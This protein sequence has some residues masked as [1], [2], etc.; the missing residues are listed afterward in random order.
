MR[1]NFLNTPG[2][3]EPSRNRRR[4]LTR[5][6]PQ[7]PPPPQ[8]SITLATATPSHAPKN[9]RKRPR[10]SQ[11]SLARPPHPQLRIR[12]TQ[13]RTAGGTVSA[14]LRRAIGAGSS[15]QVSQSNES[16]LE[17]P[18]NNTLNNKKLLV[19]ENFEKF[20]FK[21]RPK[22]AASGGTLL[23]TAYDSLCPQTLLASSAARR[24]ELEH[25]PGPPGKPFE[26]WATVGHL[27]IEAYARVHVEVPGLGIKLGDYNFAIVPDHVLQDWKS[28]ILVGRK[29]TKRLLSDE[30]LSAEIRNVLEH[31]ANQQRPLVAV[32][33]PQPVI[34]YGQSSYSIDD[35]EQQLMIKELST[36]PIR[37]LERPKASSELLSSG[38]NQQTY[39]PT[40]RQQ[41]NLPSFPSAN[42]EAL[43]YTPMTSYSPAFPSSMNGVWNQDLC[44]PSLPPCQEHGSL[45]GDAVSGS[46]M[47]DFG[48]D[49]PFNSAFSNDNMSS[50]SNFPSFPAIG[51]L[52]MGYLESLGQPMDYGFQTTEAATQGQTPFN[53]QAPNNMLEWPFTET[54]IQPPSKR[55]G[56]QHELPLPGFLVSK[57]L[58]E[59]TYSPNEDCE[60]SS[61]K[62]DAHHPD[63]ES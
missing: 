4:P 27:V 13:R 47:E 10:P 36:E 21:I 18:F 31:I 26:T 48:G 12:T 56:D 54:Y 61:D 30:G 51:P 60:A 43:Q 45:H 1:G 8:P 15:A 20:S 40:S 49:S 5:N 19:A 25:I 62:P 33:S 7:P 29:P 32:K 2:L 28:D 37:E 52:P 16:R 58:N 9:S 38:Y 35:V 14:G 11:E 6:R 24:L 34:D 63:G 46:G 53:A 39:P 3:D 57:P 23:R 59:S 44:D 42:G 50:F 22:D 55:P 41:S 17:L